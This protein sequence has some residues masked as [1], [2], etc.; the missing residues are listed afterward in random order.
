GHQLV[1][2]V[3]EWA[4]QLDLPELGAEPV[5]QV[6]DPAGVDAA[7]TARRLGG[8]GLAR[9]RPAVAGERPDGPGQE[10]LPRDHGPSAA[11]R[12]ASSSDARRSAES[13]GEPWP[14]RVPATSTTR[15]SWSRYASHPWQ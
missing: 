8:H 3:L 10:E 7:G 4:V 15:S 9:R 1:A 6:L 13:T 5:R 14:L 12:K 11:R 2:G